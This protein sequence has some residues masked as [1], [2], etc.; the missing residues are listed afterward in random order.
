MLE[1]ALRG[2]MAPI[3]GICFSS[4]GRWLASA[5]ED[6]TVRI[7]DLARWKPGEGLPP[8]RTFRGH[9]DRVNAVA[10]S[11]EGKLLASASRDQHGRWPSVAGSQSN[12]VWLML[13][14]I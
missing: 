4:D 10:F 1:Q 8:V 3:S 7:W 2:H 13:V 6:H 11:P 5:G 14:E 12:E 9:T